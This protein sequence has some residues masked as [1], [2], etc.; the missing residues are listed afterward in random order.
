MLIK[1]IR[2]IKTDIWRIRLQDL[3]FL[4][5]FIVKLFRI[6]LL[7]IRKFHE[8]RCLLRAS[9][10]T[11]YS[12]LSLGPVAALAL[13]IAKGFGFESLLQKQ[14]FDKFPGQE[15]VLFQIINYAGRLIENTKGGMIAGFGVAVLFWSVL[16]V[17]GHIERSF[18][19]IWRIRKSRAFKRK[20]SNYLAFM[21]ITPILVLMSSSLPVFITTQ[22]AA[23]TEKVDL[24]KIFSPFIFSGLK[25]LPYFLLWILFTFIYLLMPNTKVTFKSGLLAGIV[26][27]TIYQLAQL[28]YIYLQVAIA[29]NNPVYASLIALP[30]LLIWLQASWAIILIG[31]EVSFA[32][33]NVDMYEFEPDYLKISPHF[34]KLLSLQIAHLVIDKFAKGENPLT[35][36]QIS[37]ALEIPIRMVHRILDELV[38]CNIISDTKTDEYEAFTYQPALDINL[39]TIKYI[40]DALD[41]RGVSHIPVAQTKELNAL[42]ESLEELGETIEQSPAN[43]LLKDI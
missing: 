31:A 23:I 14:L 5:G 22:I 16:K 32:H 38:A 4:K 35:A 17:L 28:G 2:F 19:D 29:K 21:L 40:V 41:Q 10:L 6:V 11:F 18:N 42:S 37:Q 3:P 27:G 26:A 36:T 24:I 43:K 33:Q 12:L 15:E 1:T 8:D 30:L 34:K 13:G 9:A 7:A 20:I 39:L 25:L